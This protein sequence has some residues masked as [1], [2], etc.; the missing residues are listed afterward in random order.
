MILPALGQ[1]FGRITGIV[2]T[3]DGESARRAMVYTFDDEDNLQR[4]I[5]DGRGYYIFEQ[6]PAGECHIIATLVDVG[7]AES[8]L[9]V[10]ANRHHI[11]NLVLREDDRDTGSVIGTVSFADGEVVAN[12]NVLIE[13]NFIDNFQTQ[14]DG[15]GAFAFNQVPIGDYHIT[16]TLENVGTAED[17]LEVNAD[18]ET[19][20]NLIFQPITEWRDVNYAG[21]ENPA[22]SLDIFIPDEGESPFPVI[23]YIHGGGWANGDKSQN[24][25][26]IWEELNN[27]YAFVSINYRLSGEAIYPAQ[28][29]DCKGAIRFLRAN[30]DEYGIDPYR[31]GVIGSSAGGHLAVLL[32][33]SAEVGEYTIG[34][35]TMDI[36]GDIGGNLEFSSRVQAV[37]DWFGPI[38]LEAMDNGNPESHMARLIGGL[39]YEFPDRWTLA[40]PLTYKD[41]SD[42][43]FHIVHGTGDRTVPFDQ[44]V[45]LFDEFQPLYSPILKDL[46]LHLVEG[47]GH[48]FAPT[49]N[50]ETWGSMMEFFGRT[51]RFPYRLYPLNPGNETVVDSLPLEFSWQESIVPGLSYQIELTSTD[52]VEVQTVTLD[53]DEGAE[54][55]IDMELLRGYTNWIWQVK[56]YREDELTAYSDSLGFE[57]DWETIDSNFVRDDHKRPITGF[58]LDDIYPNP[59]NGIATIKYNLHNACNVSLSILDLQGRQIQVLFNGRQRTGEYQVVLNGKMLPSGTYVLRIVAGVRIQS[60][61]LVIIK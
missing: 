50:D 12:A 9:E 29:N 49:R 40:N 6:V 23:V 10:V 57:I 38:D 1:D 44:S 30:A 60:R 20:I 3:E 39:F 52:S 34:D 51:L 37:S 18:Q 32:G 54:H 58:V 61:K 19:E 16:A 31:M 56:G 41:E 4:T 36:E 8:G 43:P 42:A 5:T 17:D 55:E 27:D 48:G 33:T 25:P 26:W 59:L 15:E 7:R 11:I 53:L 14:T 13:G 28:I 21:N 45:L 24:A 2:T 47:A 46:E 35:E 22:Q